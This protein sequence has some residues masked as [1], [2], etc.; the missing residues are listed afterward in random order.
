MRADPPGERGGHAGEFEVELRIADRRLGGVDGGLR[1]AL[2]GGPGINIL[3]AA[4]VSPLELLGT[5]KLRLAECRLCLRGLK[6]RDSLIEPDLERPRV[7][8]KQRIALVHDLPVL[9]VDRGEDAADLGPQLHAVHRRELAKKAAGGL[10]RLLQRPADGDLGWRRRRGGRHLMGVPDLLPAHRR[11]DRQ[12]GEHRKH[13]PPSAPA[14]RGAIWRPSPS[15]RLRSATSRP[16][17]ET[18]LGEMLSM[19]YPLKSIGGTL[20]R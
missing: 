3:H 20:L 12:H 6:L 9:E 1:A 2:I 16:L 15:L 18:P 13:A 11:H 4:E 8:D 7:D 10:H 5:P 17:S 19:R 14:Q